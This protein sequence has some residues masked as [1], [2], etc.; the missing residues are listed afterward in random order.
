MNVLEQAAEVLE[1]G[2]CRRN[3]VDDSGDKFCAL[4]AIAAVKLGLTRD[5][6]EENPGLEN[7]M[8]DKLEEMEEVKVLAETILDDEVRGNATGVVFNFND[9]QHSVEPVI[10]MMKLAAKRLD[11]KL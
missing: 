10:E 1:N 5:M 3:L 6:L 8:Y 2:W 4:G 11:V 7:E 9:D